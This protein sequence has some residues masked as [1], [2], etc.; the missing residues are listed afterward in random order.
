MGVSKAWQA[1]EKIL[2]SQALSYLVEAQDGLDSLGLF[3]L[4]DDLEAIRI[5][6]ERLNPTKEVSTYFRKCWRLTSIPRCCLKG[7]ARI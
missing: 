7:I 5:A 2:A 6:I 3:G 1:D 4:V